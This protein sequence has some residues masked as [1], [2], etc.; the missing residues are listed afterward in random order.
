ML[1]VELFC[2]CHGLSALSIGWG[3]HCVYSH[4]TQVSPKA[5]SVPLTQQLLGVVEAAQALP[6][7]MH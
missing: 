1:H 6:S 5:S 2:P 3:V 7:D 4:H